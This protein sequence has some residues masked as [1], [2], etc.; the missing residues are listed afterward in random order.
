MYDNLFSTVPLNSLE[1][2]KL[3]ASFT[4]RNT[5]LLD[6]LLLL[7]KGPF[8][9]WNQKEEMRMGIKYILMFGYCN[10]LSFLLLNE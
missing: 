3:G 8:G 10:H 5:E 4:L 6:D 2:L 1:N 7:T 9:Y